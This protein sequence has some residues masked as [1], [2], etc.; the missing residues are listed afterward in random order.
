MHKHK[1][2]QKIQV[3]ASITTWIIDYLTD[4]SQF[5]SLKGCARRWTAAPQETVLLP[6]LFTLHLRLP[7]QQRVLSSSE[8][9]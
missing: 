6:F 9:L 5:V 1:E 3:D 4:R 7:V 2:L 8:I